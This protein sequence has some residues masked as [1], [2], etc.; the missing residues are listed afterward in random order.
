MVGMIMMGIFVASVRLF[1]DR[2]HLR[3]LVKKQRLQFSAAYLIGYA[4]IF[5]IGAWLMDW[6]ETLAV[7]SFVQTIIFFG[8]FFIVFFVVQVL[9]VY[10]APASYKEEVS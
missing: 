3:K 6:S 8:L 5:G 1:M 10:I 9:L 7:H 4:I 2:H